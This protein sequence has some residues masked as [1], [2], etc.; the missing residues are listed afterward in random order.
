[1]KIKVYYFGYIRKDG[2][3]N[4][5]VVDTEK[6]I[7][8]N[9]PRCYYGSDLAFIEAHMSRDVDSFREKVIAEGY[10]EGVIE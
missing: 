8:N 5:I 1:M 6:K 7:Y 10:K 9:D 4:A 2:T 3:N